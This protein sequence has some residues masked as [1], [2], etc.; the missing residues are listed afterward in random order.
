LRAAIGKQI[1]QEI[2]MNSRP[3]FLVLALVFVGF[4]A[5]H[6][7]SNDA[8]FQKG[9]IV[10]VEKV[11][12]TGG[13]TTTRG[14]DAPSTS[15]VNHYNLSIQVGDTIYVCRARVQPEASFSWPEGKKVNVRVSGKTMY[16]K[17]STGKI[18]KF[19]I[20]ST[21]KAS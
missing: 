8:D 9:K 16:V 15:Q 2:R 5:A 7:Q 17:R 14:T 13:P 21:K 6:A 11:S 4:L 3:I 19:S 10:A 1:T 20:L 18:T 12:S